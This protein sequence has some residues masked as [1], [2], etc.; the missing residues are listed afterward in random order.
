MNALSQAQHVAL[1]E[2]KEAKVP[3]DY[4][5]VSGPKTTSTN[6]ITNNKKKK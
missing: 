3:Y 1:L 5:P 4:Q 2:Q 6:K